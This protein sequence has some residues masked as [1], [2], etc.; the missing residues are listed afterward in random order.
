MTF[1]H[2]EDSLTDENVF[3]YLELFKDLQEPTKTFL[4]YSLDIASRLNSQGLSGEYALFGGYAVLSNLMD[5]FGESIARVWRGSKDIDIV[6]NYRVLNSIR[7]GYNVSN[8]L[9]SSNVPDKRTLKLNTFGE[10]DCKIDFS[11]GDCNKRYG[12]SKVNNHFG[13]PLG[14]IKPEFIIRNKLYTP[15]EE[16]QHYEDILSMISVLERQG[17]EPKD[18]TNL[19]DHEQSKELKKRIIVGEN[20]FS[21]D[22]FGFFPGNKFLTDLKKKLH[23]QRP[24]YL[25]FNKSLEATR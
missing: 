2:L 5:S 25:P 18:I 15:K 20:E 9:K 24:L 4:G 23:N 8:D 13:I 3:S 12:E 1:G 11:L 22:R 19:L 7:A 6:G 16:F 21:K 10:E 17:Y 14:I